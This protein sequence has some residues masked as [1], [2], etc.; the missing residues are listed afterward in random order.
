LPA[1][2][3]DDN[4]P[5]SQQNEALITTLERYHN[6]HP[7]LNCRA[8]KLLGVFFDEHLSFDFH[9]THIQKKLTRSLYCIKMAK[10]NLNPVGLRSL[11]FALIHSHLSYCPIILNC[12]NASSLNKLVK[13]QKKAIRIITKSQYNA[14][15]GPLFTSHKI[16]PLQKVILQAKLS[17]MHAYH[18]KYAPKSFNNTWISNAARHGDLNLRND[19]LYALP[20]PRIEF[21][22]KIPLYALPLE[23]NNAGVLSLYGNKTTFK[24][25]L[26]NHIFSELEEQNLNVN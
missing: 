15:T 12:A 18:Y 1:V 13:I 11:Y 8:Y 6:N 2:I 26:R 19:D 24:I 22:K 14:H 10:N 17:F 23:W 25:A 5:N 3:Y 16:L 21:F 4:E 9:I 20:N 7:D